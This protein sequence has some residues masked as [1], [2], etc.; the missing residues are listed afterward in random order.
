[1]KKTYILIAAIILTLPLLCLLLISLYIGISIR[2]IENK[3]RIKR[4]Y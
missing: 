4:W 3:G 1:M 2:M